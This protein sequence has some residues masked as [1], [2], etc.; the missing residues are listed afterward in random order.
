MRNQ[1]VGIDIGRVIGRGDARQRG[2]LVHVDVIRHW[3]G[4]GRPE[5]VR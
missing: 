1:L 2:E 3:R 4:Q 5:A